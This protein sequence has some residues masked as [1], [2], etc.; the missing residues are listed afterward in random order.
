MGL[1][2]SL[3]TT[4]RRAATTS[5]L[6]SVTSAPYPAP[7]VATPMPA[8]ATTSPLSSATQA[9]IRATAPTTTTTSPISSAVSAATTRASG[10]TSPTTPSTPTPP[11]TPPPAPPPAPPP[12]GNTPLPA[13]TPIPSNTADPYAQ[14]RRE[15]EAAAAAAA[16]AGGAY[17]VG[18]YNG[19]YQYTPMGA[20]TPS[21]SQLQQAWNSQRAL[22]GPAAPFMIPTNEPLT[23]E[24]VPLLGMNLWWQTQQMSEM[25]RARAYQELANATN[26]IGQSPESALARQY[27]A[28]ML[29]SGGPYNQQY[30][31][32]QSAAIRDQQARAYQ[33]ATE[34]MQQQ[35]AQRGVEGS[36]SDRDLA[37]LQQE[38]ALRAQGLLTDL[39][40]E[41]TGKN[42]E[43]QQMALQQL[44]GIAGRE[45]QSRLAMADVIGRLFSE[46]ERAIPEGLLAAM[47]Q[48]PE[49][50]NRI[51]GDQF[52]MGPA[53]VPAPAV[54]QG[55]ANW[56]DFWD[57]ILRRVS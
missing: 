40:R 57:A 50:G 21:S 53:G 12:T 46:T 7:T 25:D 43:A 41:T 54:P 29:Q 5:P 44:E 8:T 2:D 1:F 39:S 30:I 28:Q 37:L 6:T 52:R 42:W 24:D 17:Q 31:E 26:S 47:M 38:A 10:T 3:L 56:G 45:E 13:G 35:I 11:P 36:A 27:A 20:V 16:S 23:V 48:K 55:Q 14:A 34:Q 19:Q 9:V 4:T 51:V 15:A 33:R 18:P 49:E 22:L 32:Q